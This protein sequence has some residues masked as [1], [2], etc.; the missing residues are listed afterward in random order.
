MSLMINLD[1]EGYKVT[2]NSSTTYLAKTKLEAEL[3]A[4]HWLHRPH[5]KKKCPICLKLII[6]PKPHNTIK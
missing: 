3:C 2:I 4:K 6:Y 1:S 5:D